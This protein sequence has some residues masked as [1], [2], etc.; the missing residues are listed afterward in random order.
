MSTVWSG[1]SVASTELETLGEKSRVTFLTIN[2][3]DNQPETCLIIT[4]NDTC[5]CESIRNDLC[6]LPL[7]ITI[8]DISK[9]QSKRF[10][11]D[12]RINLSRFTGRT[13]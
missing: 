8:S 3:H 5:T 1:E 12:N 9:N 13:C 4:I 2:D 6:D 10:D 11:D 7:I